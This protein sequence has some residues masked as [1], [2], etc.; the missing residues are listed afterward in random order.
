MSICL[1]GTLT[2]YSTLAF[3]SARQGEIATRLEAYDSLRRII[4]Q[5]STGVAE[6]SPKS[7]QTKLLFHE[8]ESVELVDA[9]ISTLLKEFAAKHSVEITRSG[10]V[11]MENSGG[12]RWATVAVEV[13]GLEAAIYN[14]VRQIETSKPALFVTK[15]QLR[16]NVLPGSAEAI[17]IPMSSEMTISGAMLPVATD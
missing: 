11:A 12:T 5:G 4:N 15:L 1:A 6:S 2:V 17:E 3:L 8:G 10:N 13:T 16:G 7:E 9:N 14:F